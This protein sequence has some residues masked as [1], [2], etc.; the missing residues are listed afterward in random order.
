MGTV[1]RWSFIIMKSIFDLRIL[2]RSR[3]LNKNK[4]S[5]DNVQFKKKIINFKPKLAE[6]KL[7]M[8]ITFIILIWIQ[9]EIKISS[10]YS[11][12]LLPKKIIWRMF[13]LS[14][15][16]KCYTEAKYLYGLSMKTS[17]DTFWGKPKDIWQNFAAITSL[18]RNY[19]SACTS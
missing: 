9:H 18:Y 5:I 19:C 12:P 15:F 4:L 17:S 10:F 2:F 6:T 11:P 14:F 16:F 8:K 1:V 13:F 3:S 7:Y